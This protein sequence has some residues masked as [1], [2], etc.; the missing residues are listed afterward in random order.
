MFVGA[1]S[2]D[3]NYGL[4]SEFVIHV[5]YRATNV[6]FTN[7]T[8]KTRVVNIKYDTR[9]VSEYVHTYY[10]TWLVETH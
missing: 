9:L 5:T 6:I 1:P 8:F 7:V 10:M 2:S 3:Q 4:N